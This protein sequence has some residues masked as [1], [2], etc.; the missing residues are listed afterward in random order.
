MYYC[1]TNLVLLKVY[2][3]L[4]QSFIPFR[5]LFDKVGGYDE[6]GPG[7]PEDLLFFHKH[8]NMEGKLYKVN[9]VLIY[10]LY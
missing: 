10:L 4:P 7:T 5:I 3:L 8:L 6:S 9:E 1:S 2:P